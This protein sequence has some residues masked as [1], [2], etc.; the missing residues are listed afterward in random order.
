MDRYVTVGLGVLAGAAL[1][2]AALIPGIVVAG[3]AV[4]APRLVRQVGRGLFQSR[5]GAPKWTATAARRPSTT[6]RPIMA[7]VGASE[8]AA[9]VLA[10]PNG[11]AVRR[12]SPIPVGLLEALQVREAVAKTITFRIVATLTDFTT[13]YLVGSLAGLSGIGLIAGPVFYLVHETVWNYYVEL[14]RVTVDVPALLK[15][16]PGG[17]PAEGGFR[18][19]R[20]LAKTITF[21]GF[22]T[23][24]DFSTNLIVVGDLATATGLSAV[25]FVVGPFVYI[26][27]EK[28][29]ERIRARW[30]RDS[31][32]QPQADLAT[33][34]AAG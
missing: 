12:W 15:P 11:S 18:V 4:L 19:S 3:A 31:A 22:G 30:G 20:A 25:G 24:I 28:V 5:P 23:V 26:G 7:A 17:A 29:W 2:E 9:D 32:E 1:I 27:H 34:P 8:T 10:V 13:N 6:T 21:R 33:V 16:A 14:S